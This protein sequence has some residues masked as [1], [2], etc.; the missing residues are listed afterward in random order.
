M[1]RILHQQDGAFHH[2]QNDCISLL[3]ASAAFLPVSLWV[4]T[5]TR[6]VPV[7]CA[8]REKTSLLPLL[9]RWLLVS[10]PDRKGMVCFLSTVGRALTA[11]DLI[12]TSEVLERRE[13]D[14]SVV[15]EPLWFTL[16]R[17]IQDPSDGGT[18]CLWQFLTPSGSFLA[19]D[20]YRTSLV[21]SNIAA[22]WE[23]DASTLRLVCRLDDTM[24]LREHYRQSWN[25]QTISFVQL[26]RD[27][28]LCFLLRPMT[29]RE[30]LQMADFLPADPFVRSGVVNGSG[31]CSLRSLCFYS[32]ELVQQ[33]GHP[34]WLQILALIYHL[35]RLVRVL[36]EDNRVL[37]QAENGEATYDWTPA[38]ESRVVGC[39]DPPSA[40]GYDLRPPF[41]DTDDRDD[42][43]GG[44]C[45][46]S[47]GMYSPSC[48]FDQALLTFTGPEYMYHFLKYNQAQIPEDGLKM[49]RLA[50]LVDWHS[51]GAYRGIAN[52]DDKDV[53]SLA[54]DFNEMLTRA[55]W[56]TT[57]ITGMNQLTSDDCEELWSETYS[58]IASKYGLD[59]LLKW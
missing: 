28:Y 4:R 48:G 1:E 16:V 42:E 23:S 26:L 2:L 59:A 17:T 15:D 21:G 51:R 40:K 49:L 46:G 27:R 58:D 14:H 56:E 3:D 53:Q 24:S 25:S 8:R 34:D 18:S 9:D 19:C 5:G 37:L 38:V 57:A 6:I 20:P 12:P 41:D 13:S 36:E 7:R 44:G 52:D 10:K 33:H 29:L 43:D 55:Y 45:Y 31:R 11:S 32:A 47:Q 54:V 39:P 35:G 30:A 50:S 22:L